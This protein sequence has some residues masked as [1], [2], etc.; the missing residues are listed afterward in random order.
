MAAGTAY[1]K[2]YAGGF[3]DKPTLTTPI[4]SAFL[5]AVE[6]ALLQ[7]IGNAPTADGQVMQW[8]DAQTKYGPALL[9]NKNIDAAAAIAK[10]KLDFT[11]ANGI[12]NADVAGAAAIARSKLDFGAGLV[13]ADISAAA[14]LAISKF[15]GYPA[16]ATKVL[17]GDGSWATIFIPIGGEWTFSGKNN[18]SKT[19]ITMTTRNF[20]DMSGSDWTASA[21]YTVPAAGKYLCLARGQMSGQSGAGSGHF[22]LERQNSSAVLQETLGESDSVN[23]N[24]PLAMTGAFVTCNASDRIVLST[25]NGATGTAGSMDGKVS[26]IRFS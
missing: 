11:G 3:V 12:V 21:F 14:A 4:D 24:L 8:V 7:L 25:S 15:A 23:L 1:A 2:R 26:I 18:G 10:S 5:N 13:N 19:A 16:D 20:D 22:W 9:L 17:K 6:A